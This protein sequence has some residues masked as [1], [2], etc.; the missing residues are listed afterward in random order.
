MK[1]LFLAFYAVIDVLGFVKW[2]FPLKVIGMNS[3]AIYM[4]QVVIDCWLFLYF[5]YRKNVF[6]KV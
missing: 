4:A 1:F 6:L 3:I 5:L 2:S